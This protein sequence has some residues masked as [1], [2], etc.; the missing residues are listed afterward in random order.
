MA[1]PDN[2]VKPTGLKKKNNLY[3]CLRNHL[4]TV[5]DGHQRAIKKLQNLPGQSLNR[6]HDLLAYNLLYWG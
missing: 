1:C 5:T 6:Q 4:G 2:M 3:R